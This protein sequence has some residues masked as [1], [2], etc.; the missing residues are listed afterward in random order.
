MP[1]EAKPEVIRLYSQIEERLEKIIQEASPCAHI[2]VPLDTSPASIV[3]ARIVR[4]AKP[5]M[6][7]FCIVTG[8]H[9]DFP[10]DLYNYFR[11]KLGKNRI[12]R[13][14]YDVDKCIDYCAVLKET[15]GVNVFDSLRLQAQ[16]RNIFL[17][18]KY[19]EKHPIIISTFDLFSHLLGIGDDKLSYP[20]FQELFYDE[21]IDLGE[22]VG[23]KRSSLMTLYTHSGITNGTNDKIRPLLKADLLSLSKNTGIGFYE[24]YECFIYLIRSTIG[25]LDLKEEE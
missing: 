17:Y 18:E 21:I 16:L 5:N 11:P 1:Y 12:D 24:I 6:S 25:L 19:K 2:V 9:D 10:E 23:F 8:Y 7:H 22:H 3:A 15:K 14:E 20:I 4:N 13:L